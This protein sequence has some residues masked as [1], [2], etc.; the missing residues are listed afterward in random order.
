MTP[1]ERKRDI[2]AF[3]D[4][5]LPRYE[6]VKQFI[7]SRIESGEWP[8][9]HRIPSE[10][11][12]VADLGVS[13]MTANRALRELASEGAITRVQGVGSFVAAHKGSTALLE[14]RNIADEIRERGHRHTSRIDL[15]EEKPA[16]P[17]IADALGLATGARVFHSIIVHAENGVPIQIEDR[18]VNPVICP[19]YL[20]QD[21]ASLTP[22]AYLTLV[23]PITRTEQIVEA[24]LPQSWECKLLAIGRNEPCL[25]I[26]RRTWSD[27]RNVTV[28][29]L[30]YPGTR[31]RLEGISQ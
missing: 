21:F 4:G 6:A 11:D 12:I 7:R 24:V 1:M 26:R 22:N 29:R 20:A 23:A 27:T 17:E 31:Y 2:T 8:A 9:H 10:N 15:L 3:E 28:A 18:F 19:D 14:V 13:R 25:M 30:L 16:S 5:P